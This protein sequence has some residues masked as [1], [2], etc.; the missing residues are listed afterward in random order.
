MVSK[1]IQQLIKPSPEQEQRILFFTGKGGVG[2]TAASSATAYWLAQEGYETL[3]VTT[4]PADHLSQMFSIEVESDPQS[5]EKQSNL[6]VARVDQ[7]KALE[8]HKEKILSEAREKYDEKRLQAVKEELNSPCTEEM[9]AFQ[10]FISFVTEDAYDVIIFDTAPTGHTLRLLELPMDWDDQMEM[11]VASEFKEKTDS[12]KENPYQEV[13]ELL[14]NPDI[15]SFVFV[16]YPENTPIM[17]AYR[18]SEDLEEAGIETNLVVA[19]KIL[20]PE[21]CTTDFFKK[22]YKLQQKHFS[23]IKELFGTPVVSLPLLN[24]EIK[25]L[26]TLK[27][28]GKLLW[29]KDNNMEGLKDESGR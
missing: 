12:E 23:R 24:K 11:M 21:Y 10:K 15:T 1:N 3:L 18:A 6:S 22:R 7:E 13:I 14:R 26:E 19:N 29:E 20:L 9:A 28:A 17:E 5:L 4:D 2:K 27:E 25:G 8:E 16:V